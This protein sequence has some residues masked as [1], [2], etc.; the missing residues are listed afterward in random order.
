M[1]AIAYQL[2]VFTA[3]RILQGIADNFEELNN[4]VM[5]WGLPN[6]G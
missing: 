2:F 3:K 1:W 6:L 4:E 5:H